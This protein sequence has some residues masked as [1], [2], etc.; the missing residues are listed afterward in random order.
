[1]ELPRGA[2]CRGGEGG[3]GHIIHHVS[4]YKTRLPTSLPACNFDSAHTGILASMTR[5]WTKKTGNVHVHTCGNIMD[6][7]WDALVKL[8]QSYLQGEDEYRPPRARGSEHLRRA[9]TA[10]GEGVRRGRGPCQLGEGN[11]EF[12]RTS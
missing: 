2:Q 8:H 9:L 7:L 11:P 4:P 12:S 3:A 10:V 6:A 5:A 1:M